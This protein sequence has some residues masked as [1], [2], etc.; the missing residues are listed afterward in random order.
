MHF[1]DRPCRL[2]LVVLAVACVAT[3]V[4]A[5]PA[6]A[7]AGRLAP[8]TPAFQRWLD[9]GVG[10]LSFVPAAH[11]LGHI[12][13]PLAAPTVQPSARTLNAAQ[14]LA[15]AYPATYDLRVDG[16][17][18]PVRDQGIYGTCWV[19]ATIGSLE[20]SLLP[21]EIWDF[22]EDNV[23]LNAGFDNGGDPYNYGGWGSWTAA[24]L[25]RWD[26]PVT[27]AQEPYPSFTT[28]PGLTPAKHLQS[29]LR[30]PEPSSPAANDVIKAALVQYGAV[31]AAL[32]W[33]QS[34]YRVVTAGGTSYPSYYYAGSV[35]AN[36]E[37]DIVGWDDA[38][39]K[40]RFA[41]TPP[42]DG[43][44]LCRNSWG[45]DW[46]NKGY[47]WVSYYDSVITTDTDV[48]P[49][50]QATDNYSRI[51]Q[52]D[53]LGETQDY[54][55]GSST[56][57]MANRFTAAATESL[58]AVG[59]WVPSGQA[60]Y[61]VYAGP[62]LDQLVQVAAGTAQYAGYQTVDL[63]SGEHMALTQGRPFVV[64]VKLTTPK[65]SYPIPV[66]Y[67]YA[68]YSNAAI[69]AAGQ[70]FVSANGTSWSDL[71]TASGYANTNVCLKAYTSTAPGQDLS[72]PRTTVS[73]ADS[74]WH[75][76]AVQLT[77]TATATG[78]PF[79]ETLYRIDAGAWQTSTSATTLVTIAAPAGG[80]NDGV[81]TVTYHSVDALGHAEIDRTCTVRIDTV[82]PSGH[83]RVPAT[84]VATGRLATVYYRVDDV[85]PRAH[86][87]LMVWRLHGRL[88]QRLD[89]GLVPTGRRLSLRL[90]CTFGRGSFTVTLGRA[91]TDLAG[92]PL[93]AATR[94]GILV[95]R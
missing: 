39:P 35:P 92:N 94:T 71:T 18:T 50:A 42:G 7:L 29:W 17:V 75:R 91:T 60:S 45:T 36:H 12:P 46:G 87:V 22:S 26:G 70:S 27:E 66:E 51:Y 8:V 25:L 30:L 24:Y 47:F 52:Y 49:A 1:T 85:S 56:G 54:G 2:V 82:G 13:A 86:V 19:F 6:S 67:P 84:S 38:Y 11:G 63:A 34:S 43:A 69:A 20:S 10:R 14:A 5:P 80:G 33:T 57:W 32:Y 65:Y 61:T 15:G 31:D 76:T 58:A 53:P 23:V 59:L 41:S 78:S 62:T 77:L 79:A 95:V 88:M 89:L 72:A 21:G 74:A 93:K 64:A 3:G 16:R 55:L 68:G 44:Y 48:F 83:T 40:G 4:A 28:P 81:H 9:A 37:I 90:P 73:G